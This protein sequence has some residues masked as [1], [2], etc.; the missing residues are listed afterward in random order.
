M[1]YVWAIALFVAMAAPAWAEPP[2]G[3]G[4]RYAQDPA[5]RATLPTKAV[6]IKLKR[7]AEGKYSWEITG[8]D[9][10]RVLEADRKL[11]AYAEDKKK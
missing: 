2:Q 11:K 3:A 5:L 9:A 1:R 6:A 7:T 8:E 4:M 10:E